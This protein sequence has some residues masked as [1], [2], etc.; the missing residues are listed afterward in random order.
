M[1]SSQQITL[2]PVKDNTLYE[3]ADG[4]T[5]N[6]SG[7]YLFAGRVGATGGGAKRRALL[8]FDLG[9]TI[10]SGAT[11]TSVTLTLTASK[12]A[13]SSNATILLRR[14]NADWGEGASNAN[15]QEGTGAAAA[16]GDATWINRIKGTLNWTAAGGD[17]QT[18]QSAAVS[19]G[20]TGEYTVASTAQLVAD[21]QGWRTTPSSNFG[22]ILLGDESSTNTAK[23]FNARENATASTRPQLTITYTAGTS[24]ED[25]RMRPVEF[26]IVGNYPN[27]FNPSTEIVFTM[28]SESHATLAVYSLLGEKVATLVDG[29]IS[30][31]R[32]AVTWSAAGVA[33]GVYLGVLEVGTHRYIRR[34][35]LTK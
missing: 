14:V 21:V 17:F 25:D 28:A 4:S 5:S 32:H 31:G 20:G 24:V 9:T 15:S 12:V 33:S 10:P 2:T 6:G 7:D 23:R 27:P 13:S 16:T 35:V 22:W 26:E 34:M 3:T 29:R 11:I 8:K 30:M 18:T 19:V 1:S